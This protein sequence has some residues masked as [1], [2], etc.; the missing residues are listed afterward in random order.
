MR[1]K[2]AK[3]RQ[4]KT[5]ETAQPAGGEV[6]APRG[7]PLDPAVRGVLE[8]QVGRDLRG[9]RVHHDPVATDALQARA[10]T[11]GS[12]IVFGTTKPDW[13]LLAHEAAHAGAAG[14]QPLIFRQTAEEIVALYDL[15]DVIDKT[16]LAIRLAR[17]ASDGEYALATEVI[18]LIGYFD[19]DD[20]CASM[21]EV[22]LVSQLIAMGR[23]EA[24]RGLL[25]TIRG[26]LQGGWTDEEEGSK[27]LLLGAVLGVGVTRNIWNR[28]RIGQIEGDDLQRLAGM[29]DDQ[30]I[31]DDGTVAGRL[32]AILDVTSH[33]VIPGLQTGIEFSDTGFRGTRDP[34]GP[35]FRDPH[36]SSQNQ[37]G[38]F[39]TAVGL[40]FRPEIVSRPIPL[41]GAT[42]R[43]LVHA[44][45]AMS[46]E[47]VAL[48]L[49]IGHEK[50]P[51]PPGGLEAA[52]SILMAGLAE[53]WFGHAPEGE[54]EEERNQRVGRA[55]EHETRRRIRQIIAAFTAQ[56]NAT[57]DA[58]IAAWN[59]TLGRIGMDTAAN[60]AAV[61]GP[62]S[63][64]EGISINPALRGNSR[65]DL[66]LSLMGW[67][68]GQMIRDGAFADNHDVAA[69]IR[70]NLGP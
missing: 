35:G 42:I 61:E 25:Q 69:W 14:T 20:V 59:E 38:H 16:L 64:L 53:D 70:A 2:G 52:V 62:G 37:P 9:V 6:S 5:P 58:D 27:S 23:S 26:E 21:L 17:M 36:R 54:T 57:T 28:E 39:L 1:E 48:R 12:D 11:A 41:W 47:E 34:N 31:V 22:L 45:R 15:N 4:S 44:P 13:R 10:F 65:Q 46:D 33:M 63:P 49:T 50:A 43:D 66:R 32:D 18:G 3:A 24:G 56:F 55:L 40:L 19:R 67:R 8:P 60:A 7:A 51:D 30:Q 29:F 68:L